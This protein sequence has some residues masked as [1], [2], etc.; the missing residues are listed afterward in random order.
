M[1]K[2]YDHNDITIIMVAYFPSKKI[3]NDLI[4][5]I[6]NNIGV[7]IIQN[8][9]SDLEYIINLKKNLR[10]IKAKK[11][12]GNGAGINIGFRN[13]KTHFCLYL[14]IDILLESNFFQNLMKRMNSKVNFSVLIPNINN[15]Y[16]SVKL[17]ENY[18][19]EGSIMLFNMKKFNKDF[20]FDEKFFLYYEETDFFYR[21]KISN[22]KIYIDPNL[23]AKHKRASSI[24]IKNYE[25]N[26]MYLRAWHLMWSK[27]YFYK[28]NFNYLIAIKN[29]FFEFI[30]DL[31]MIII[32]SFKIDK[33]NFFVRLHR[34]SGLLCSCMGFKSYLRFKK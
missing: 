28:K 16:S 32:F 6:P 3:L 14:D 4:K 25:Y 27:F 17:I 5:S 30:K 20:N 22:K 11:N 33:H 8:C 13:V 34:I 1:K 24:K 23:F 15:K 29:T 12:L 10:I 21:C 26:I 18:D 9:N 19:T 7:I 2:K 31:I